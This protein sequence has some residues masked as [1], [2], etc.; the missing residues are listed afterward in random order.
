MHDTM[1]VYLQLDNSHSDISADVEQKIRM[2]DELLKE[3][4]W[5]YTGFRNMYKPLSGTDP[6]ETFHKAEHAVLDAE[7]LKQYKPYLLVGVQTNIC[8]L[9]EIVIRDMSPVSEEKMQKYKEYYVRKK[10]YAH[11]IVVDENNVLR[12]GYTTYLLAKDGGVSPDIMRVRNSQVFRK[13]V[14][15]RHVHRVKGGFE[16]LGAKVYAWYYNRKEAVVPGDILCVNTTKG[17][18]YMRVEGIR[19]AA[20][21]Q[22]CARHKTVRRHTGLTY[23]QAAVEDERD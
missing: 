3:H 19:Y 7:W 22:E 13:V 1:F 21:P 20:G 8:S 10:Q 12:D 18:G 14:Y 11:G 6:D 2:I 17:I 16:V 9:N 23:V 4:G 5:Q 15:G